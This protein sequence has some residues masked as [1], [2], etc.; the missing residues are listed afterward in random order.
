MFPEGTKYQIFWVVIDNRRGS[1]TATFDPKSGDATIYLQKG[2]TRLT[3]IDLSNTFKDPDASRKISKAFKEAYIPIEV[4]KGEM[5]STI[6]LFSAFNLL[7]MRS[8]TW[9]LAGEEPKPMKRKPLTQQDKAHYKLEPI[10]EAP[11]EKE[12]K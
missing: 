2:N 1:A 8:A 12:K 5:K 9:S 3:P 10:G 6:A 7:D 11:K 4:P